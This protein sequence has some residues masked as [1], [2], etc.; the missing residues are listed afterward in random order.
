M[1]MF[2]NI[3]EILQFQ[4][5]PVTRENV[6]RIAVE[7]YRALKSEYHFCTFLIKGLVL[8]VYMIDAIEEEN[9]DKSLWRNRQ[10]QGT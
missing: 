3:R 1:Y 2:D 4:K 8:R 10:T 6:N 7:L 5:K 9:E